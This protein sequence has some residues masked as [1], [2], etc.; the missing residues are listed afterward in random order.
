MGPTERSNP[1]TGRRAQEKLEA[2]G[3]FKIVSY[4]DSITAGGEASTPE[5][6]F[7]SRFAD[8]LRAKF[9]KAKIELVDVS[10]PG[11][12]SQQ[13][14]D[15]FDQKV[16]PVEKPDFVL[17]G[18]GMNDHNKGGPEPELFERTRHDRRSHSRTARGQRDPI[19]G[20]PPQRQLA[21]R[22]A[23]NGQIRRGHCQAAADADCTYADV[24]ATWEMV[25]KRKDQSS[26]LN[27]NI[28]HPN[29]SATGCTNKP[30]RQ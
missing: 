12:S 13:G 25:L 9:P 27:N 21:L 24:F 23:S 26:L 15:W 28:N 6:R 8:Y 19:F 7:T 11:Y 5:F 1:A 3:P 30:S 2:G 10:I 22:L 18:F 14:I 29:D 4:G 16:G 20:V 17:V